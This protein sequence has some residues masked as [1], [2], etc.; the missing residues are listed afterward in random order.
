M[1]PETNPRR[2]AIGIFALG[3]LVGIMVSLL[4]MFTTAYFMFYGPD[5]GMETVTLFIMLFTFG[6]SASL[7]LGLVSIIRKERPLWPA[8]ICAT[9]P[10]IPLGI[11]V[12]HLFSLRH[13]S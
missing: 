10:L 4:V 12:N 6:P 9:I 5:A 2:C 3:L 8:I 1:P 7:L 11:W 13:F